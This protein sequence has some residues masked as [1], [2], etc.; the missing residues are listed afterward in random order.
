MYQDYFLSCRLHNFYV[1]TFL[2][3]AFCANPYF[4][5][6]LDTPLFYSVGRGVAVGRRNPSAIFESPRNTCA[7][8]LCGAIEKASSSECLIKKC[9]RHKLGCLWHRAHFFP[10]CFEPPFHLPKS[11][12][13]DTK[14]KPLLSTSCGQLNELSTRQ[15][16]S[17]LMRYFPYRSPDIFL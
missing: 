11:T 3:F 9:A 7:V 1:E 17:L 2:G 16:T 13:Q 6:M 10:V 8:S 15:K 12:I 14:C 4:L 5:S